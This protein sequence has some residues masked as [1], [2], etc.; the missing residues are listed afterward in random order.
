V[1]A[2]LVEE[3][4]AR[5]HEVTLYATGD[6]RAPAEVRSHYDAAIWPPNPYQELTHSAH[7][8]YDLLRRGEGDVDVVHMHAPSALAFARL[9][10]LPVVYTIH[11]DREDALNDL[12]RLCLASN[13]T[14]VAISER[15]R[16]LHADVCPA[17]VVHHGIP[18]AR[19]PL[20]DGKG[21]YAAF[22]GRFAREKG[23]HAAID[24]ALRAGVPIRLAGQPHW[25]DEAYYRS[26][27]ET[28]LRRKGVTWMGEASHE[29]K[30]S[31]LGGALATLF[32]I[33]WEEPFG[34][35]MIESMLCGTPVIAFGRGAAPEI[36]DEG[37][38]GWIVRDV[39]EMAARLTRLATERE[40]F[41][42]E[43]CRAI[44]A[45]RFSAER[46]VDDYL[47]I[48]TLAI[49]GIQPHETVQSAR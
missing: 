18:P 8:V 4:S 44:A 40:P 29:P 23:P 19:Y 10:D 41:D 2:N 24:A 45:R 39:D 11:N 27:V 20:G 9:L 26:E 21:R 32:P 1:I 49:H 38:T 25:K 16:A 48:Y 15:Q 5:G 12:Y 46:M 30:V 6:S 14:M 22:L 43:A 17:E 13:V 7:A 42:R 33:G 34:L 36:V 37:V 47:A 31:L 3:L 28:R 35:V